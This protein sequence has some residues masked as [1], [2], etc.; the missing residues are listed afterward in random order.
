MK[1]YKIVS[2]T[3]AVSKAGKNYWR[4]DTD[5]GL[6]SCFDQ[7]MADACIKH[8]GQTVECEIS[9]SKD[10]RFASIKDIAGFSDSSSDKVVSSGKSDGAIRA[11]VAFKGVIDLVCAGKLD[12]EH[13]EAKTAIYTAMLRTIGEKL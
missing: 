4:I 3:E 13:I 7:D 11:A 6:L 2:I 8:Q 12:V 1:K 9:L 5:Q 10:G